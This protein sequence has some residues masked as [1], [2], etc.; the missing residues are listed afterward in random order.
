M[1]PRPA[2]SYLATVLPTVDMTTM[3][4][5]YFPRAESGL[6][7]NTIDQTWFAS[8]ACH[9]YARVSQKT[10]NN[11]GYSTV[12]VPNVYD[13]GYM[14]MGTGGHRNEVGPGRGGHLRQ[15]LR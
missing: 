14:E 5:T 13:F 6:G 4:S 15:Q 12:F 11:A 7:V 9:E 8:A 1:A 10:A 3:Y 2:Q